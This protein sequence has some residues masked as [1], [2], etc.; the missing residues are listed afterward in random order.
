VVWGLTSRPPVS[1]CGLSSGFPV[2]P[3][4]SPPSS[5]FLWFPFVRRSPV[6]F[7]RPLPGSGSPSVSLP[8]HFPLSNLYVSAAVGRFRG[9]WS[10]AAGSNVTGSSAI[11]LFGSRDR[12]ALQM[13]GGWAASDVAI[14]SPV[15]SGRE[16]RTS[17]RP[18]RPDWRLLA[19]AARTNPLRGQRALEET[20]SRIG[21]AA[22]RD[23]VIGLEQGRISR[24]SQPD[25][26][27]S[28]GR[29]RPNPEFRMFRVVQHEWEETGMHLRY[30]WARRPAVAGGSVR[31]VHA[32]S[33]RATPSPPS[34]SQAARNA[35]TTTR[36][37]TV[38]VT[39]R[40][41]SY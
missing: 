6:C 31:H 3:R 38:P 25:A 39:Q 22:S 5:A 29:P 21:T 16:H 36:F 15:T 18:N 41:L 14:E 1:P 23:A 10:R 40:P 37:T 9:R 17:P 2:C 34:R 33:S 32:V 11:P 27:T 12:P 30:L 26:T 7:P 13:G 28:R 8:V 24:S 35:V 19:R 20:R 4:G